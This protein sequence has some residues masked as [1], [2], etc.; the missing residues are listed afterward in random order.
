MEGNFNKHVGSS[1]V[2][3]CRKRIQ[4]GFRIFPHYSNISHNVF[5]FLLISLLLMLA[6]KISAIPYNWKVLKRLASHRFRQ[7]LQIIALTLVIVVFY[8]C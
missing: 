5:P 6:L 3:F 7:R 8:G 1:N 4:S 2:E